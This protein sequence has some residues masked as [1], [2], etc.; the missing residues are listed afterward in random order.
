[1]GFLGDPQH[2]TEQV[3]P[4]LAARAGWDRRRVHSFLEAPF[5]GS[6]PGLQGQNNP[7]P[8]TLGDHQPGTLQFLVRPALA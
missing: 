4:Y 3:L 6:L 5:L 2:R 1:M 8:S 7:S